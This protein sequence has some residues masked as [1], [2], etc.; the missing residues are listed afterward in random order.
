[1]TFSRRVLASA[2]KGLT[3]LLCRIDASELERVPRQGPLILVGNHINFLEVPVV[4]THLQPRPLAVLVKAQSRAHPFLGLFFKIFGGR[5]AIPLR[6]GEADRQALQRGMAA[7]EA[8]QILAVAP[9]GTRS[10]DGRLQRGYPGVV[11]LALHCGARILPMACHGSERFW[12][13]LPRLRRTDF[14]IRVGHPFYLEAGS[15]RV[16]HEVRQHMTDEIMYQMAALLP[17]AYR[18]MYADLDAATE[19][20]LRFPEGSGSNL[21]AALRR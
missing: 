8:G 17:P 14:I 9:E 4:Y 20:Y 11:L 18:G 16:T 21:Q 15:A 3:R 5:N 12:H 6:I 2:L 7:L 13:N 19:T 1:M 10:G